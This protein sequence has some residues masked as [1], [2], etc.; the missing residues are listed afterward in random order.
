MID[1]KTKQDFI[2]SALNSIS[3]WSNNGVWI[4]LNDKGNE[5]VYKWV[6]D[7]ECK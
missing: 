5:G 2:N 1:D 7:T 3:A 6:T 4:G